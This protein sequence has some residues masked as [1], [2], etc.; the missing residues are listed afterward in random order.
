MSGRAIQAQDDAGG[1][2]VHVHLK[3]VPGASRAGLAGAYGDRLKVR[4]TAA[5][6]SG[7]ANEAVLA[8]LAQALGIPSQQLTL[9]RGASAPRKT[10]AVTGLGV[11]DVR[12]RLLP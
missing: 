6:E 1:P 8:L 11:A 10:I 5:A 4:V 3:V 12:A 9:V 7:K 2:R